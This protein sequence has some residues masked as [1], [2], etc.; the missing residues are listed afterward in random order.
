MITKDKRNILKRLTVLFLSSL[1]ITSCSN[2]ALSFNYHKVSYDDIETINKIFDESKFDKELTKEEV[3][4]NA[5]NLWYSS[6]ADILSSLTTY[7]CYSEASDTNNENLYHEY[8]FGF[9]KN[10]NYM[11]EEEFYVYH[12]SAEILGMVVDGYSIYYTINRIAYLFNDSLS[13]LSL[14]K[15]YSVTI[16]NNDNDPLISWITDESSIYQRDNFFISQSSFNNQFYA[17]TGSKINLLYENFINELSNYSVKYNSKDELYYF[18]DNTRKAIYN[19][20]LLN[21]Y[22]YSEETQPFMGDFF[23]ETEI[24]TKEMT[25]R[26]YDSNDIKLLDLNEKSSNLTFNVGNV[27]E[28][29]DRDL[30]YKQN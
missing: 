1:F 9:D 10:Q 18:N 30:F 19:K 20:D 5:S 29:F 13:N 23:M 24:N 17:K 11:N 3:D 16:I 8:N 4:N 28:D 7:K 14:T 26:K 6:S 12:T 27:K 21:E 22:Y 2:K 15:H 25:S